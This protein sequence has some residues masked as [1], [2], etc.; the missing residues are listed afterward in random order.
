[1]D[2]SVT[3]DIDRKLRL[4]AALLGAHARKDLAAAFRRVNPNTTFDVTRADKWLHGRAKPRD[5]RVY[6]DWSKLL[7]LDRPSPWIAGCDYEEF[8]VEVAVRH[9][10]DPEE[11]RQ[12]LDA[13]GRPPVPEAPGVSLA[14]TYACYAHSWSP[15]FR[16]RVVRG[17]FFIG[18]RA[19]ATGR[20]AGRADQLAVRYAEVLPTGLLQLDGTVTVDKRSLRIEVRDATQVSQYVALTLYPPSPPVSVLAGLMFGTTLIGP[21]AEPSSTRV[22][23]I[24][25]PGPSERLEREE[26]YLPAGASIARDLQALGLPVAEP[27]TVDRL[28]EAHLRGGA[29]DGVDQVSGTAYRELLELFD[30]NWLTRGAALAAAPNVSLFP[31]RVVRARR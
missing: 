27:G 8:L 14:G 26:A 18:T 25:L 30:R 31:P 20:S 21:D 12:R 15:Y 9:G 19:R 24:R 22:V 13:Q 1:M 4:T 16:G 29:R 23:L 3:R 11:L 6:E 5:P 10:H 17:S 2:G 28:L 7:G